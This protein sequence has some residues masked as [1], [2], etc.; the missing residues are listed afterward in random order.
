[1]STGVMA[2][3]VLKPL[4]GSYASLFPSVSLSCLFLNSPRLFCVPGARSPR[5]PRYDRHLC[6]RRRKGLGVRRLR[7]ALAAAGQLAEPRR[8]AVPLR[9]RRC[10]FKRTRAQ[11]HT[12]HYRLAPKMQ[13]ACLRPRV[14]SRVGCTTALKMRVA[15][16]SAVHV[17]GGSPS[18]FRP[19]F[20]RHFEARL[21]LGGAPNSQGS[22]DQFTWVRHR[23]ATTE[24]ALTDDGLAAPVREQ[25]ILMQ[26]AALNSFFVLRAFKFSSSRLSVQY[27]FDSCVFV[28]VCF[29]F[30][31]LCV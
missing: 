30:G 3:P 28:C 18:G 7:R 23:G 16:S 21:A 15:L 20:T 10:A 4:V 6:L 17:G 9:G 8:G 25:N 26:H 24:S 19:A 22:T 12:E 2:G 14:S 31:G 1:M 29:F 13:L 11:Q 27:A 5:P